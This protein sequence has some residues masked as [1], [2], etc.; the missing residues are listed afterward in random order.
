MDIKKKDEIK[1]KKNPKKKNK[2]NCFLIFLSS[3]LILLSIKMINEVNS[4]MA[5][6]IRIP[7]GFQIR[8]TL[9]YNFINKFQKQK[10]RQFFIIFHYTN[11][12]YYEDYFSFT[13]FNFVLRIFKSEFVFVENVNGGYLKRYKKFKFLFEKKVD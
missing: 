2:I 1:K 13:L 4:I 10:S 9:P 6:P 5:F 3:L 11:G 7:I 8:L 12:N